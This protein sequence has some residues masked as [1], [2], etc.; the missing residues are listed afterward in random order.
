[1]TFF[2]FCKYFIQIHV[3]VLYQKA[4]YINEPIFCNKKNGSIFEFTV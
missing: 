1:M 2:D 4:N 3:C